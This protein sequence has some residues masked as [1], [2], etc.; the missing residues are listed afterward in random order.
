MRFKN[1]TTIPPCGQK[2][3]FL[4]VNLRVHKLVTWL[5]EL[6]AHLW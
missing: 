2:K 5:G 6:H 3:E 4:N 1:N